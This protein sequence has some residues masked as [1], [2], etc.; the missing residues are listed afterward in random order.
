MRRLVFLTFA[1]AVVFASPA[2][3]QTESVA[4][5][6]Y[7]QYAPPGGAEIQSIEEGLEDAID[8]VESDGSA[9]EGAEAY[10]EALSPEAAQAEEV[11]S[12]QASSEE[13]NSEKADASVRYRRL[14]D[15]G[16]FPFAPMAGAILVAL[17]GGLMMRR[18]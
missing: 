16:G 18:K 6:Q 5:S 2:L 17:V 13:A 1:L 7:D 11:D 3:A 9:A 14:P 12:E 10:V 8:D 4:R 15:T